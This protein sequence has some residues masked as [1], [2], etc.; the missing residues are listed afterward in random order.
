MF[1]FGLLF[2]IG[3]FF[4][5]HKRKPG[6]HRHGTFLEITV[7]R[8]YRSDELSSSIDNAQH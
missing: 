3:L 2:I 4:L 8:F 5:Y 7:A 6:L 1:L